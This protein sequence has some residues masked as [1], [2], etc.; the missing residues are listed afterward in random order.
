[1]ARF[2]DILRADEL[3]AAKDKL[4]AWQRLDR[5]AKQAAYK[6]AVGDHKRV[7]RASR[8]AYIQPF[9]S[10]D[11]FWYEAKALAPAAVTP[12]PQTTEENDTALITALL[13]AVSPSATTGYVLGSAPTGANNISNR[14]KKIQFAKVRITQRSGNGEPGKI[15]RMTGLPY[16]KYN[17]N[18]IS[19]PFGVNQASTDKSEQRARKDLQ[20]ALRAN[21]RTVGFTPQ[22]DVGNVVV[23][24]PAAPTT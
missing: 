4:E 24:P 6:A 12:E 21:N 1:M 3:K 20:T 11:N 13:L 10:P 18:T 14:A 16:T 2:S 22:G 15:S 17:T 5:A 7:N 9:G 19:T 23:V 8:T